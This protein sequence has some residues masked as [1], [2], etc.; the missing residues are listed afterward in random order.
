[1]GHPIIANRYDLD[2]LFELNGE[3]PTTLAKRNSKDNRI[4]AFFGGGAV[5]SWFVVFPVIAGPVET[6]CVRWL[7]GKLLWD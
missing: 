5:L 4:Q 6:M 2:L 3:F 1:M 7:C